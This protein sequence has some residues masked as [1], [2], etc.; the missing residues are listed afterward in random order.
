MYPHPNPLKQKL[1]ADQCITGL[2][3][4]T[5]SADCIEIAAVAGFDYVIIDQEH[6]NFGFSETV[7][8]IRAAEAARICPMVRVPDHGATSIRKA[9]E[10]GAMGIFVPD[11]D[12]AEQARQVIAAAKYCYQGNGG[13]KGACPTNRAARSQGRDWEGY[14]KWSNDN[15]L[16]TL[17]VESQEGI[18]NLDEILA[19][20]GIDS[21]ALGRFDL[22]HEMGL[23]G[24]RY[25]PELEDVFRRFVASAKAAGM[26]YFSRLGSLDHDTAKAQCEA[27]VADGAR[28]FTMGSDRQFIDRVFREVLRPMGIES[29]AG[30]T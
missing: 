5:P 16:L 29:T 10:A 6:G 17:L 27:L 26:R 4:Q 3:I 18:G 28:M 19:V 25:G 1:A 24:G 7:H 8:L 20:P 23:H 15:V 13:T 30:A 21:V 12:T 22:A 9:M 11:V 2:F 14:V